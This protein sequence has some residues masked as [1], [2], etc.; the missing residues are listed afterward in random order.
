MKD[1]IEKYG[2]DNKQ[3]HH[4]LRCEEF[5]KRYINGVPYEE[6]LIPLNPQ[7][8]VDIKAKYVYNLEQAREIANNV[9]FIVKDIKQKYMDTHCVV[10]NTDA[11][12]IMDRTLI[13]VLR[14]EFKKEI[15]N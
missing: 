6:C 3:L 11:D 12:I 2:Y 4:I 8:L 10:I 7:H 13:D 1:K 14:R 9:E 15:N 5:L